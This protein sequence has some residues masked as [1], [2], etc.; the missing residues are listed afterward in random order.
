M[1]KSKIFSL[2]VGGIV[3]L[4]MLIFA[5]SFFE[6]GMF[7]FFRPRRENI[8]RQ[9]FEETK[10]YVHGKVQD[11]AKYYR[12]YHGTED[13]GDRE[14]IATVI[15]MQFAEFDASQ[16]RETKLRQFLIKTRGY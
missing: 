15:R 16:I 14:V 10:S 2:T 6:L 3:L 11:L 12:E 13:L 8:K 5:L 9:V 1:K 7:K 4:L